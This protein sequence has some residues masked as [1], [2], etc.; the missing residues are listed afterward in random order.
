MA[1]DLAEDIS[2]P[3]V[4]S[5][6]IDIAFAADGDKICLL[7]TEVLLHAAASD[8]ARSKNQRDWTLRNAVLLPP[9]LTE[10]AILHGELD[11]GELLKI[12]AR[13]I[14]EWAKEEETAS[15]EG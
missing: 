10:D 9:F 4:V 8:L 13:S 12:F 5:L 7:I 6:K 15:G 1:F 14:T 11:T 2:S 3:S